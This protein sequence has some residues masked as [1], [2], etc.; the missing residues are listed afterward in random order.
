MDW[1]QPYCIAASMA[2]PKLSSLALAAELANAPAISLSPQVSASMVIS[3]T[4]PTIAY[5]MYPDDLA[6]SLDPHRH[7]TAEISM[8]I[9]AVVQ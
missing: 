4:T 5:T 9:I 7:S 3:T 8:V 2:W 1:K 6:S